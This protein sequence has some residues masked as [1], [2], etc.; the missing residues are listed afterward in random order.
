MRFSRQEYWS[1]LP[2]PPQ[3]DLPNLGIKPRSPT[4][5]VDS[6]PSE[7]PGKPMNTRVGSLSLL[8]GIVSDLGIEPGSPALQVD[9]LPAELPGKYLLSDHGMWDPSFPTRDGT[10]IRCIAKCILNHWTTREVPGLPVFTQPA[11]LPY[12]HNSSHLP[13]CPLHHCYKKILKSCLILL[14]SL[15]SE[16]ADIS[17]FLGVPFYFVKRSHFLL[18]FRICS[19]SKHHLSTFNVSGCFQAPE[20]QRQTS[21]ASCSHGT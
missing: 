1:G 10:Y 4:L 2:S 9:S 3:G 13:L 21:P 17:T 8:L 5:Q 20:I 7:A 18:C 12:L 16:G 11:F 15:R 6:L 19:S 14:L